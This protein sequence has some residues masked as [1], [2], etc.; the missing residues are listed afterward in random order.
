MKLRPV[1][2]YTKVGGLFLFARVLDKIRKDA[3]GELHELHQP[4]LG[5]GLDDRLCQF[6]RVEYSALREQVLAGRT[7]E[8]IFAW[9]QQHGRGLNEV[10]VLVWNGFVSKRGWRDETSD[11]LEA[12]K[13]KRGI[14]HRTDIVTFFDFYEVDEGRAPR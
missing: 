1:S 2:G 10:D 9:C 14:A 13:A 6:L 7:D 5:K 4:F 11:A 8:E 12:D 3:R